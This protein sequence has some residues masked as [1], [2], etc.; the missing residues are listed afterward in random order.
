MLFTSIVTRALQSCVLLA[1]NCR[2]EILAS[3]GRGHEAERK[4]PDRR[5][6]TRPSLGM[7]KAHNLG[8]FYDA[9]SDGRAHFAQSVGAVLS[10]DSSRALLRQDLVAL[11]RCLNLRSQ[12][13]ILIR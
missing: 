12:E 7:D 2:R 11:V 9:V 5:Q 13:C 6:G 10:L 4:T 1:L 3:R 8:G